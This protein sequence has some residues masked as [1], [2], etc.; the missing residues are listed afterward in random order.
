MASAG[1]VGLSGVGLGTTGGARTTRLCKPATWKGGE[2]IRSRNFFVIGRPQMKTITLSN[3]HGTQAARIRLALCAVSGAASRRCPRRAGS[4]GGAAASTRGSLSGCFHRSF[5]CQN[6]SNKPVAAIEQIEATISTSQ[7]PRK[8][9]I[10][11]CGIAKAAPAVSATGHTPV[12][13]RKPAMAQTT[14][15]GTISEKNGSCR[16]TIWESA[17]S[18]MPVTLLSAIIGVPSAPKAT[19]AVF[20]IKESPAA[21]SGL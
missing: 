11:N 8:L 13:P 4:W 6:L 15:N 12:M 10:R 14:Q 5:G 20:A 19:G 21:A 17:I 3:S 7:G 16:P 9:E 18:L 2:E 1:F